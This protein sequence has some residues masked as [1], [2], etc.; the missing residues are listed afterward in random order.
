M[1]LHGKPKAGRTHHLD[2]H[3]KTK[4]VSKAANTHR[5]E[6]RAEITD[7]GSNDKGHSINRQSSSGIGFQNGSLRK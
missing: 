3:L 7:G 4:A 5:V 1:C 2:L 6:K